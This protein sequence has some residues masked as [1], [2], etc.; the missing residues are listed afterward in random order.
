MLLWTS[1]ALLDLN[2]ILQY[3]S[4]YNENVTIKVA[5]EFDMAIS[6]IEK[7]PQIGVLGRKVQTRELFLSHYPYVIIYRIN[8]ADIEILRLLHTHQK[9]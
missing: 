2:N 1:L 5:K 3:F 4:E 9:W 6:N 7:F 8:D